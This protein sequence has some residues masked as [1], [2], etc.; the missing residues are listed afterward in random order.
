MHSEE[1]SE[2]PA[3]YPALTPFIEALHEPHDILHESAERIDSVFRRPNQGLSLELESYRASHIAWAKEL[4]SYI[5]KA[6]LA[7]G[8]SPELNLELDPEKFQFG[9]FIAKVERQ[10]SGYDKDVIA[11]IER[12]KEP[13]DALHLS[14]E[15]IQEHVLS[16]NISMAAEVYQNESEVHLQK[17]EAIFARG[18]ARE[19]ELLAG[20]NAAKTIYIEETLPA[21]AVTQAGLKALLEEAEKYILTDEKML[22]A[23]ASTK[24]LILCLSVIAIVGA[25][26]VAVLLSRSII[27]KLSRVASAL[28]AGSEQTSQAA[29]MLS[30]SS[31]T[32]AE[33]AAEQAASL[34][35][36]S[37]SLEEMSSMTEN[38]ASN[39]AKA[40]EVA[41]TTSDAAKIGAEKMSEMK[42]AMETIQES[43]DEI[44]N[45]IKTIDE[46]AFQTNILALNAAV[47]A[48]RAGDA[49]QG[50]AVVAEEV[51]SLAQRSALAAQDTA[52]K[53]EDAVSKNEEGVR[54]SNE[55]NEGLVG[56][57]YRFA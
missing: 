13:H 22:A 27:R 41:A 17:I 40:K 7:D 20:F 57:L 16:G 38:N 8:V 15:A 18:I 9:R 1:C 24:T 42:V 46:I 33:G 52:K 3:A 44:R 36:T 11:M 34:E 48:A 56:I 12:I 43:S 53:I 10:N 14:A 6:S 51:R 37:S 32:L 35:E 55:V 31:Q 26:A 5:T 54:L 28:A 29:T 25:V 4:S 50:F 21:L 47:E 45:I 2:V 49:G 30:E 23:V 39:A 19:K